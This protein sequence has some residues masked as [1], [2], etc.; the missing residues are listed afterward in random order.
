M[1]VLWP[2]NVSLQRTTT[3]LYSFVYWFR[4]LYTFFSESLNHPIRL[5]VAS[6]KNKIVCIVLCSTHM[7]KTSFRYDSLWTPWSKVVLCLDLFFFLA[8]K[9]KMMMRIWAESRDASQHGKSPSIENVCP[10]KMMIIRCTNVSIVDIL[11]GAF[12]HNTNLTTSNMSE[13][14]VDFEKKS[15][16][17]DGLKFRINSELRNCYNSTGIEFIEMIWD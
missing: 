16:L 4:T 12:F 6:S 15:K 11:Y 13:Y 3:P 10:K 9:K 8:M 1:G 5:S 17:I 2:R 7:C 14:Q